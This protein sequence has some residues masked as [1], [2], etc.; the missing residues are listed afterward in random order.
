[1]YE[2]DAY[3][4]KAIHA[5]DLTIEIGYRVQPHFLHES[6]KKFSIDERRNGKDSLYQPD[7]SL[8]KGYVLTASVHKK[9]KELV[10]YYQSIVKR[11]KEYNKDLHSGDLYFW[12]RP[13]LIRKG[14]IAAGFAWYD[15]YTEA[16]AFLKVLLSDQKGWIFDD[17]DQGW[18]LAVYADE[19]WFYFFEGDWDSK[20]YSG[21]KTDK[22]SF[23]QQVT[24][25]ITRTESQLEIL[26]RELETNYWIRK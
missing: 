23:V 13:L 18:H 9:E 6:D 26:V 2:L 15:T 10:R 11:A 14:K 1:M 7:L 17:M 16:Q 4:P 5:P 3:L 25:L 24:Q 19:T 20:K 22:Q 21:F 12:M 8:F